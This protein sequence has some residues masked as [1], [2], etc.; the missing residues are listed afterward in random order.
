MS[1]NIQKRITINS[2]NYTMQL[3]YNNKMI[4][5]RFLESYN[6]KLTAHGN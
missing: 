6:K 3:S 5:K 1:V 2:T 4:Y